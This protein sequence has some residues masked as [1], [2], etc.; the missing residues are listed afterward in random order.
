MQVGAATPVGP[1]PGSRDAATVGRGKPQS[2]CF[3][4]VVMHDAAEHILTADPSIALIGRERDRPALAQPLVRAALVI[5]GRVH[6]QHAQ[7]LV[8]ALAAGCARPADLRK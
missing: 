2:G 7:Q 6:R 8:Q 4:E 1:L 3:P 5:E